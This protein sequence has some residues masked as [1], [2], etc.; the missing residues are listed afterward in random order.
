MHWIVNSKLAFLSGVAYWCYMV[1]KI[2]TILWH[3]DLALWSGVLHWR[4]NLDFAIEDIM[5]CFELALWSGVL[6]WRF[7][8]FRCHTS[9]RSPIREIGSVGAALKT[10]G[11][12]HDSLFVHLET[13]IR[14]MRTYACSQH[15]L[16]FCLMNPALSRFAYSFLAVFYSATCSC[17]EC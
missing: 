3:F 11:S 10:C 1:F 2:G 13:G 7:F 5:L 4:Y 9:S 8:F 16:F 17:L 14:R 12:P 6:N 15:T